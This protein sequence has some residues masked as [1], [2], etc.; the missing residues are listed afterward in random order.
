MIL[1]GPFQL[2]L[3]NDSIYHCM[4]LL[5]ESLKNN[6]EKASDTKCT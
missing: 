3:F 5:Y 6:N 2:A 1:I 4:T